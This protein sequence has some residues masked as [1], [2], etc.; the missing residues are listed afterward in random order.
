MGAIGLS[1]KKTHEEF[2]AEVFKKNPNLE[3]LSTYTNSHDNVD[4]YCKKHNLYFSMKAYALVASRTKCGCKLCGYELVSEKGHYPFEEVKVEIEKAQPTFEIYGE[5]FG[6]EW[7][8]LCR[9]KICGNEWKGNAR[10][11]KANGCAK[12]SGVK[13][14]TTEE[15][16]NELAKISPDIDVV[17]EYKARH[18]NIKC[19]CKICGH[20]WNS[21]P[22]NLL[23]GWGCPKCKASRGE[24]KIAAHLD[25][26]NIIY[27]RE[28]SFKDC[29]DEHVLLYDFYLPDKNMCIEYDG[30]QHYRP[31]K[32]GGKNDKKA[33]NRFAATQKRDAIK[34][35]YCKEKGIEL[36]RIPYTEFD[37]VENILDKYLL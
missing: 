26:L 12:C 10:R 4:L 34:T 23:V 19:K 17:G 37:N 30:E 21:Q 22:G 25:A 14:K 16:A 6:K 18:K 33:E 20:E 2:V 35:Q 24:R 11:L 15:F 7:E 27:D 31:V 9:C 28:K 8:Y 36:I 13:K 29:K 5:T 1:K 3:V 32:F